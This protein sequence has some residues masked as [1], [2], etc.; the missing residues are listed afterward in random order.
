MN[1]SSNQCFRFLVALWLR[2]R[3]NESASAALK[4]CR[5]ESEKECTTGNSARLARQKVL[6]HHK[7]PGK[8]CS[9]AHPRVLCA[10]LYTITNLIFYRLSPYVHTD[11]VIAAAAS[12]STFLNE[13]FEL[14][15]LLSTVPVVPIQ[16]CVVSEVNYLS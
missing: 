3:Q 6:S 16:G 12:R 1:R 14:W 4:K 8:L 9:K 10:N 7:E 5:G 13:H 2:R 11:S 15:W